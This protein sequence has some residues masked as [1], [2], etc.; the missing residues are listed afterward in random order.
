MI[1]GKWDKIPWEYVEKHHMDHVSV[2]H[3]EGHRRGPRCTGVADDVCG[4][5]GD[6]KHGD[7]DVS[8]ETQA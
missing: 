3:D 4:R 2:N 6:K 8:G 5:C 7:D 1:T